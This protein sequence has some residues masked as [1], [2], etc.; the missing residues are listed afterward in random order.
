MELIWNSDFIESNAAGFRLGT[1]QR[2]ALLKCERSRKCCAS[3][4]RPAESTFFLSNAS[5]ARSQRPWTS[6]QKDGGVVIQFATNAKT[7]S[8][9]PE[10]PTIFSGAE[11][12]TAPAGGNWSKLHKH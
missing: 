2:L 8:G 9:L 6:S 10:P 4:T 11:T 3:S 12:I 1:I 5:R 7:L